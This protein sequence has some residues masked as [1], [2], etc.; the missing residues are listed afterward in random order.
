MAYGVLFSQVA[1]PIQHVYH[2]R[3][4]G[5]L[6]ILLKKSNILAPKDQMGQSPDSEK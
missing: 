2:G 5:P 1:Q 3:S 4:M 6:Q